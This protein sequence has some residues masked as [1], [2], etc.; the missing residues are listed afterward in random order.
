MR[1][2]GTGISDV[3]LQSIYICALTA[4]PDVD[5]A[6]NAF[7]LVDRVLDVAAHVGEDIDRIV[8]RSVLLIR[9]TRRGG[10]ASYRR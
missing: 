5:L 6:E 9:S 7:V 4:H 3:G 10:T 1:N 2:I 8:L